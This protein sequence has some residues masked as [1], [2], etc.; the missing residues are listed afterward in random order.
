MRHYS[1]LQLPGKRLWQ[2]GSRPL[3]PGNNNRMRRNGLKLCQWRVRLVIR[4]NRKSGDAL[5]RLPREVVE[6]PFLEVFKKMVDVS[7]SDM[8]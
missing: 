6:S 4:T 8:V 7:L 3:L 5:H 1:S 2:G